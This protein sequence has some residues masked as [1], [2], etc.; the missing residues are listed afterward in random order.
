MDNPYFAHPS[1]L[2]RALCSKLG[3]MYCPI[4]GAEYRSDFTVCSDCEVSLVA[5][6]PGKPGEDAFD[7]HD[8][9]ALVWSGA[10]PRGHANA[11]EILASEGIPT[12]TISE[13][14]HLLY[15]T[16][17][18]PFEVYVP[19]AFAARAKEILKAAN[20]SE[21]SLEQLAASGVPEIPA[22]EDEDSDPKIGN[23]VRSRSMKYAM[24][25]GIED[26]KRACRIRRLERR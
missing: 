13:Q 19:S 16:V 22:V 11:C 24:T 20:A 15:A 26:E 9:F 8:S 18:A 2:R 21:E 7:N 4:C 1:Q 3:G 14:D 12:R 17:I 10:D 25:S 6:L 5:D 23:I